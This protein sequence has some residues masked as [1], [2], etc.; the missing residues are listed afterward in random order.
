MKIKTATTKKLPKVLAISV[1]PE[2]VFPLSILKSKKPILEIYGMDGDTLRIKIYANGKVTGI[3]H[4][5]VFNRIGQLVKYYNSIARQLF[6][7]TDIT[8]NKEL[9]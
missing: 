6:H 8:N 9:G 4:V 5:G 7:D 1:Q 2:E 3:G